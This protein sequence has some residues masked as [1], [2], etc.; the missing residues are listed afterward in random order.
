MCAAFPQRNLLSLDAR[1][2]NQRISGGKKISKPAGGLMRLEDHRSSKVIACVSIG[3]GLIALAVSMSMNARFGWAQA[4]SIEDRYM[5]AGLHL[6]ID[7]AA[8]ILVAMAGLFAGWRWRAAVALVCAVVLIGWSM[9]SVYGFLSSRIAV[10]AG[11]MA[12]LQVQA[13]YLKWTQGQTVNFDRPKAER[14]AMGL[15]VKD[16]VQKLASAAM[17]V[18]DAQAASIAAM[19]GVHR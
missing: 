1:T 17:I 11:H 16:A 3:I 13:D 14:Q 8:A 15:E 12:A 6:L 7:P 18:P 19:S 5:I 9:I 4:S 2:A 10:S